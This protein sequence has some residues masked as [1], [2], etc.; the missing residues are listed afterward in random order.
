MDESTI[1]ELLR[2]SYSELP[3]QE[4]GSLCLLYLLF[5]AG[6]AT[7]EAQR[8]PDIKPEYP[9]SGSHLSDTVREADQYFDF[10]EA[11][12]IRIGKYEKFEVWMIQAWALMTT[13]SLAA[14]KWNAADAYI[15][16]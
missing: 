16:K 10:V 13:C 5:A 2:T 6:S 1:Q 4:P 15:G 14:S 3:T 7:L 12:L 8:K 9:D 11:T